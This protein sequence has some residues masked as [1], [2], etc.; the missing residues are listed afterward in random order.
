MLLGGF[1]LKISSSFSTE[2]P[3]IHVIQ[4]PCLANLFAQWLT[5]RSSD[6]QA[7]HRMFNLHLEF[8]TNEVI[9]LNED[10]IKAFS[11]N[12]HIGV[13]M[14]LCFK[15]FYSDYGRMSGT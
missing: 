2:V 7:G 9:A 6:G 15:Y 13:E 11:Y 3:C 8:Y 12:M 14:M 4:V 5:N 1:T 10:V